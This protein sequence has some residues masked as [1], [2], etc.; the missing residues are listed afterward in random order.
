MGGADAYLTQEMVL[1]EG[2]PRG[3]IGHRTRGEKTL[4][5]LQTRPGTTAGMLSQALGTLAERDARLVPN[6]V[7]RRLSES[8]PA[9]NAVIEL[10]HRNGADRKSVV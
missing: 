1:T 2:R 5:L 7:S 4:V 10:H 6:P 3:P 9:W 8:G